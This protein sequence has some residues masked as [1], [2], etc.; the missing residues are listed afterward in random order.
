MPLWTDNDAH[1]AD[2]PET[3]ANAVKFLGSRQRPGDHRRIIA[4]RR[5]QAVDLRGPTVS[6]PVRLGGQDRFRCGP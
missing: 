6:L 2:M 5:M 4:Q 1:C 3:A